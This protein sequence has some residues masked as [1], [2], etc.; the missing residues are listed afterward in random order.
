MTVL[1]SLTF[2]TLPKSSVNPTFDRRA[3]I[4]ARLEEQKRLFAD[5]SYMRSIQSWKKNETGEKAIVEKR[6]VR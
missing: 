5:P 6:K 1:K 4:V 3:K 2:I